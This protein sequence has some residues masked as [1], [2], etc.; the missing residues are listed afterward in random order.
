MGIREWGRRIRTGFAL[1]NPQSRIPL[2]VAAMRP[3]KKRHEGAYGMQ[4]LGQYQVQAMV[5]LM[6]HARPAFPRA[7]S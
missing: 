5:V 2:P 6:S 1:A 4:C 3:T 7:T